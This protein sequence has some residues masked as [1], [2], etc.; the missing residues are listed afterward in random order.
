VQEVGSAR[1]SGPQIALRGSSDETPRR[2][3]R[4][5]APHQPARPRLRTW[6]PLNRLLLGVV[7]SR[8]QDSSPRGITKIMSKTRSLILRSAIPGVRQVTIVLGIA[9]LL[10]TLG[11]VL[12]AP[13][14][15]TLTISHAQLG[16]S[17]PE[18]SPG[19]P[20][21]RTSRHGGSV[22]AGRKTRARQR[23][24]RSHGSRTN[25]HRAAKEVTSSTSASTSQTSQE[26]QA[27]ASS[28]APTRR[29]R[30]RSSLSPTPRRRR[31]PP[32]PLASRPSRHRRLA[33]RRIPARM[34]R[35]RMDWVRI[36][37]ARVTR[38]GQ[39]ESTR[40]SGLAPERTAPQTGNYAGSAV[41]GQLCGPRRCA[42]QSRRHH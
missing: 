23:P 11:I 9:A 32:R 37:R 16:P 20:S 38:V 15:P 10:V 18:I 27:S 29:Q 22:R 41:R 1:P 31:S 33:T 12:A 35:A 36:S 17:A 2:P 3:E 39:V 26:Y 42:E 4:Q 25:V 40:P 14:H 8:P 34:D 19:H 30:P 6:A 24:T 7:A 5:S 21:I 28:P 13:T